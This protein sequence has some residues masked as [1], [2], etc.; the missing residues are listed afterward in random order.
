MRDHQIMTST[1]TMMDG[2][3]RG[4]YRHQW[5][6]PRLIPASI[7]L[8]EVHTGVTPDLF[9]AFWIE[10]STRGSLCFSSVHL[11]Y[12]RACQFSMDQLGY[13]SHHPA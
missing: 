11:T 5:G 10:I 4:S 1:M 6:L 8:A 12:L 3:G 7:G 13:S 2:I 9:C